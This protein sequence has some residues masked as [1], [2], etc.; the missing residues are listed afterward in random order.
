MYEASASNP[1]I[2]SKWR[3]LAPL[4]LQKKEKIASRNSRPIKAPHLLSLPVLIICLPPLFSL[5]FYTA[6]VKERT[7]TEGGSE[8]WKETDFAASARG[9]VYQD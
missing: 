7:S 6:S 5:Y 9:N 2:N 1:I 4:L 8:A 3:C